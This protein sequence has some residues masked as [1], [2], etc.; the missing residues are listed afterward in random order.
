MLS[1]S[2]MAGDECRELLLNCVKLSSDC[3]DM[4]VDI[5]EHDVSVAAQTTQF[6][7]S[8]SCFAFKNLIPQTRLYGTITTHTECL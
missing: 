8:I 4:C 3:D 6:H 2:A 1:V 5:V 7:S